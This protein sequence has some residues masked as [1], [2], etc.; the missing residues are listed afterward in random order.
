MFNCKQLGLGTKNLL[1]VSDRKRLRSCFFVRSCFFCE[2]ATSRISSKIR[3]TLVQFSSCFFSILWLHPYNTNV[4]ALVWKSLNFVLSNFSFY[5]NYILYILYIYI[6]IY[7]HTHARTHTHTHTHN[8]YNI[9]IYIIT[10]GGFVTD[11]MQHKLES[12]H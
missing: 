11:Q 4:S 10:V 7:T 12:D 1:N 2:D 6:Y 9:Y 8:I 5:W 3:R